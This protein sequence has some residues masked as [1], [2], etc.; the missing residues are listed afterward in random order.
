[1][2]G[3][4]LDLAHLRSQRGFLPWGCIRVEDADV[5]VQATRPR[6]RWM[7]TVGL[8]VPL[9]PMFHRLRGREVPVT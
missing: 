9:A 2:V 4:G 5:R 1:M 7:Q 6:S 3:E 8:A